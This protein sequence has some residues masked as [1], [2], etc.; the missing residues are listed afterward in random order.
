MI[1]GGFKIFLGLQIVLISTLILYK[2]LTNEENNFTTTTAYYSGAIVSRIDR[3][4]PG[5]F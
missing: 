3:Q 1:I 2:K 4:Q 5:A